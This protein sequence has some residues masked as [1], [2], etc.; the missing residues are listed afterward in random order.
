MQ[1]TRDPVLCFVG[2]TGVQVRC[3]EGD[4]S[5]GRVRGANR[6]IL[7][8][9]SR[10]WQTPYATGGSGARDSHTS[11]SLRRLV[12]LVAGPAGRTATGGERASS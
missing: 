12:S 9:S 8:F 2:G 5:D 4:S 11:F 10:H 3:A 6:E 7:R 1:H